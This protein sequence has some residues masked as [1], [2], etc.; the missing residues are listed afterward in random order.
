MAFSLFKRLL[1]LDTPS[2]VAAPRPSPAPSLSRVPADTQ[3]DLSERTGPA[4]M[5]HRDLMVSRE[6]QILGHHFRLRESV[7]RRHDA[8]AG[9]LTRMYDEAL[10][11][12]FIAEEALRPFGQKLI[13]LDVSIHVLDSA[14]LAALPPGQFVLILDVSTQPQPCAETAELMRRLR[15]SGYQFGIRLDGQGEAKSWLPLVDLVHL[16]MPEHHPESLSAMLTDIQSIAPHAKV[17]LADIRFYEEMQT[18]RQLPVEMLEGRYLRHREPVQ[19]GDLDAGY[20]RLLETLNL[21]RAEADA[22]DIARS[23][24]FDPLLSFKLLRFVNSPAAGLVTPV[25]SIERAVIVLGHQQLYRWLSLLLYSQAQPD[26]GQP[27]LM[28]TA[29]MRGRMME[30]LGKRLFKREHHDAL[31][32]VGL[33]SV[34][35]VMLGQPMAKIVDHLSLPAEMASALVSREGRYASLLELVLACEEGDQ[36]EADALFE[37]AHVTRLEVSRAQIEALHWMEEVG[38]AS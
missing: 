30:L 18:A 25:D 22:A 33:F 36:P 16:S 23:L 5:L 31:F 1:G 17:L 9:E 3:A 20:M 35:D 37:A 14:L 28:A 27:V 2:P 6:L 8:A 38:Q 34:L 24:K 26:G 4:T 32:T 15:A 19:P 13:C 11:R 12:H 7:Q 29:L 21:V 10:L